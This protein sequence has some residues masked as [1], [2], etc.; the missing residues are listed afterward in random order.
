M[1]FTRCSITQFIDDFI[2]DIFCRKR[3]V[4][5]DVG[6][7]RYQPQQILKK[8]L[9]IC[10]SLY[11]HL[12]SATNLEICLRSSISLARNSAANSYSCA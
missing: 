1:S 9:T 2:H 11:L 5:V 7:S 4:V 3:S 6:R 12:Q 8:L 10:F